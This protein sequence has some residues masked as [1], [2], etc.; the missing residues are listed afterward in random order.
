MKKIFDYKNYT[1]TIRVALFTS[2]YNDTDKVHRVYISSL[3]NSDFSSILVIDP[4]KSLKDEI[5]K[6]EYDIIKYVDKLILNLK[7]PEK[8]TLIELGYH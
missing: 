5:L 8:V 3:D 1:Y 4:K 2:T 7:N 6:I